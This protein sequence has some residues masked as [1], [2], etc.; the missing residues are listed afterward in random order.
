MRV[1]ELQ[2]G[3]VGVNRRGRTKHNQCPQ[4][5]V[6]FERGVCREKIFVAVH[7]GNFCIRRPAIFSHEDGAG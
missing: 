7:V 6:I 1:I 3:N 4:A 5:V 2:I